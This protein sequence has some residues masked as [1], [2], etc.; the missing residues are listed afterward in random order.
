MDVQDTLLQLASIWRAHA[1][2]SDHSACR[3]IAMELR[4]SLSALLCGDVA[5]RVGAACAAELASLVA[6]VDF[7]GQVSRVRGCPHAR[8]AFGSARDAAALLAGVLQVAALSP[9]CADVA[10]AAVTALVCAV[11]ARDARG[12][13]ALE[14]GLVGAAAAAAAARRA[15]AAAAA[16][17]AAAAA[18][19][20]PAPML[21][22]TSA[23]AL[24]QA[25]AAA[26]ECLFS[27]LG[28][29]A[30]GSGGGE[31]AREAPEQRRDDYAS[32]AARS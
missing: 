11:R 30:S 7:V 1:P 13:A 5:A 4:R 12:A 25:R 20:T 26:L 15:L 27:G 10:P 16:K 23:S 31:W 22:P 21:S 8:E 29:G 32:E 9:T 6:T 24:P 2:T 19:A 17:A 28:S 3:S 18:A 14:T